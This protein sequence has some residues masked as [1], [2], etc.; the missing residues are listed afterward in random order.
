MNLFHNYTK[1]GPGVPK[2]E[3]RKK[4]IKLFFE[5]YFRKTGT[6]I[7]LNLLYLLTL[8]PAIA[9]IWYILMFLLNTVLPLNNELLLT[10]TA[11]T[12]VL[13]VT[14]CCVFSLSPFA[15]GFHYILRNCS[16]EM[17]TFVFTDFI[18]KFRKN[19]KNSIIFFFIDLIAVCLSLFC[20]S[21]YLILSISIPLL[22]IPL[23]LF[24]IALIVYALMTPYKWSMLVTFELSKKQILKNSLFFVLGNFKTTCQHF[25]ITFL[26]ILSGLIFIYI[27]P[28]PGIIA[29]ILLGPSALGLISHLIIY[30]QIYDLIS[31]SPD[32]FDKIN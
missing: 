29:F 10:A 1:P 17:H 8:I 3:P 21:A 11:L 2:N 27:L 9:I 19:M 23:T 31:K 30:N 32:G 12:F 5:L 7:L 18:D 6:Y 14:L 4:G 28:I 15:A 25:I 13:S 24:C 26:F 20:I 16:F 22:V